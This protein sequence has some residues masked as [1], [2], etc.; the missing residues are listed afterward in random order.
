MTTTIGEEGR[1]EVRGPGAA[2]SADRMLR[3]A[4]VCGLVLW[5]ALLWVPPKNATAGK[6]QQVL[7][8]HA[9]KTPAGEVAQ[10]PEGAVTVVHFWATWCA[11][12]RKELPLLD[13][14]RATYQER[15]VR[16]AAISVDTDGDK[17]RRFLED[18]PVKLPIYID[19]PSG[20]AR[21]LDLPSLP[22]TV[23]LDAKG[24]TVLSTAQSGASAMKAISQS[25]DRT[26]AQAASRGQGE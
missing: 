3:M 17:L 22:Y 9:L 23:V 2:G 11:P 7:A 19:G 21:A 1:G 20:I 24:N 5:G 18:V 14:V 4:G 12:C 25:I 6:E 16:F 13:Q 26:L 15:G 10:L 8:G